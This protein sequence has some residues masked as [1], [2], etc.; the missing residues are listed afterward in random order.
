MTSNCSLFTHHFLQLKF[1]VIW[2][3]SRTLH[4]LNTLSNPR[5]SILTPGAVRILTSSLITDRILCYKRKMLNWPVTKNQWVWIKLT[6]VLSEQRWRL[7]SPDSE[8]LFCLAVVGMDYIELMLLS[9][10]VIFRFR[11]WK[12]I[13]FVLY[14]VH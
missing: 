11:K 3:I 1:A 10:L 13:Q 2:V 9:E 5:I 7:N 6:W 8:T 4:K 12:C 14:I